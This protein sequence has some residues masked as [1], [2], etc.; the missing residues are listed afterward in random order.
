PRPN[1]SARFQRQASPQSAEPPDGVRPAP[2]SL[3]GSRCTPARLRPVPSV[4]SCLSAFVVSRGHLICPSYSPA[5]A[6]GNPP[7]G[8]FH[9]AASPVHI[10]GP[11]WL[12][13]PI[14]AITNAIVPTVADLV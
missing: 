13:R 1:R 8:S 4:P 2:R 7:S 3:A 11:C 14:S 10:L 9:P 6:C 5:P 12:R